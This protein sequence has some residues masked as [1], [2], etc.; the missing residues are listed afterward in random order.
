[1]AD[2]EST[3]AV[4]RRL[5]RYPGCTTLVARWFIATDKV[6]MPY[7]SQA[8]ALAELQRRQADRRQA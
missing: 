8:E 5:H 3:G 7:R 1:M 6:P 4:V 2:H